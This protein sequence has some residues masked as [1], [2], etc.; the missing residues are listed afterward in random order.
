MLDS[1]ETLKVVPEYFRKTFLYLILDY[2]IQKSQYRKEQQKTKSNIGKVGSSHG[3]DVLRSLPKIDKM[4]E[5]DFNELTI[6][7]KLSAE[8]PDKESRSSVHSKVSNLSGGR[9]SRQAWVNEKS[10]GPNL[11]SRPN[12][13][14]DDDDPLDSNVKKDQNS[15]IFNEEDTVIGLEK[16]GG[17]H[18]KSSLPPITTKAQTYVKSSDEPSD[19]PGIMYD[20]GDEISSTETEILRTEEGNYYR[21]RQIG[22]PTVN[23]RIISRNEQQSPEYNS[24]LS[25]ALSPPQNWIFQVPFDADLME[26]TQDRFPLSWFKFI[27]S[28]FAQ[29]YLRL[30]EAASVNDLTTTFNL[31]SV[32]QEVEREEAIQN[33]LQDDALEESYRLLDALSYLIIFGHDSNRLTPTQ[34]QKTFLGHLQWSTELEWLLNKK[35]LYKLVLKAYRIS[36]KLS[37]DHVLIESS[38]S[39][40]WPA[41]QASIDE[42]SQSWF[43][44]SDDQ[45]ES[46]SSSELPLTKKEDKILSSDPQTWSEAVRSEMPNLFSIGYNQVKSVYTSHLVSL[47]EADVW[48]G[49]LDSETVRGFWSSLLAELLYLTNDDDERYSI[50]AHPVLL[51]NLTVQAADPPLGYPIY[52]SPPVRYGPPWFLTDPIASLKKERYSSPK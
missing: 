30:K 20:S 16:P 51:R 12:S 41:L 47:G 26:D 4:T 46:R 33:L 45:D 36:V 24:L 1:P 35:T 23:L 13:W 49:R 5:N 40:D 6:D 28:H 21:V 37:L 27:L 11:E 19:I 10:T 48:L 31:E 18:T 17:K 50:Q 42:Y 22:S 8:A 34:V 9:T 38:V 29:V 32:S 43:M 39:S 44:G 15:D 7:S 2:L 3:R 25:V 14:D 52:S